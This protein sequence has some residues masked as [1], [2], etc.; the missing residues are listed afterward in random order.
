MKKNKKEKN[1]GA[2]PPPPPSSTPVIREGFLRVNRNPADT[3]KE[4]KLSYVV[5]R[6][7]YIAYYEK[8]KPHVS[9]FH[10]S[11]INNVSA[12]EHGRTCFVQIVNI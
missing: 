9:E 5:L 10:L 4:W 8:V 3:K 1:E 11:N 6:R 2:P 7:G 12:R